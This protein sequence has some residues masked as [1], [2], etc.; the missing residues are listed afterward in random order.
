MANEVQFVFPEDQSEE[1]QFDY[2]SDMM[3]AIEESTFH[4][5]VLKIDINY[6]K[7]WMI[8]IYE[9]AEED[10]RD[11]FDSLEMVDWYTGKTLK[12]VFDY[13]MERYI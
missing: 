12:D 9:H 10:D 4:E 1:V 8:E 5:L 13:F 11:S 7:E 6:K 2:I 3:D